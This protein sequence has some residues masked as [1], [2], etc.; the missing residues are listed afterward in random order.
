MSPTMETKRLRIGVLTGGGDC[1]GLNP[2][3]R[4]VVRRAEAG[5]HT[6]VGILDGWAGLAN[7]DATLSRPLNRDEVRGIQARGGTVLGSSRTNL[8]KRE[9]G[10][11]A[12]EA[13]I[14]RLGL[15]ALV[16]IGGDDT[17]SVAA[18][19]AKRGAAVV[20]I[21]KTMD[22]DVWGTEG[23]LGFDT[24]ANIVTEALDRIQT[25]TS[26]HHRVAVVEVMGRDAGWVAAWGGLA[27][28]AD[29]ILVPEQPV[30]AAAIDRLVELVTR[31]RSYAT[32]ASVIVVSEGVQLPEA[33]L[34]LSGDVPRDEFGHP[35]L[36]KIAVG[37]AIAAIL[38][39]RTGLEVRCTRLGHLQRGGPPS[40]A[41]RVLEAVH[42]RS[43]VVVV[44]EAR[45]LHVAAR[46]LATALEKRFGRG[47]EQPAA[48][49]VVG[50]DVEGPR[51]AK[52]LAVHVTVDR[53]HLHSLCGEV[54]HLLDDRGIL[55]LDDR[56]GHAGHVGLAAEL[57]QLF[58]LP[59]RRGVVLL[60][61][62]S[63]PLRLDAELLRALDQTR[64]AGI[65]EGIVAIGDEDQTLGAGRVTA[66]S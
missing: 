5:G 57:P 28:G 16:V 61:H 27:G 37:D 33:L 6:V 20:A 46:R 55:S 17:L 53:D 34:N 59:L 14:K 32:G 43:C 15:D 31:R 54:L 56:D 39:E 24:A 7:P 65:P 44:G 50:A 38:E 40:A 2:A 1:P 18:G 9:G 3:I 13:S 21:P 62:D 60:H 22:N 26:S 48:L 36:D 63:Q 52:R 19:L 12:A 42:P 58:D 23:C 66:G 47:A 25:T 10:L 49:D 41:D 8:L 45:K 30:D 35:R 64:I 4:A 51:I 11:D 29:T